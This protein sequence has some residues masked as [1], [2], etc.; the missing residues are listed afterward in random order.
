MTEIFIEGE[1]L[2]D[3]GRHNLSPANHIILVRFQERL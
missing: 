2:V 3:V 1:H